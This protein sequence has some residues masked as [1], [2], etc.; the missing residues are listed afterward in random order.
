MLA[1]GGGCSAVAY[2]IA[3]SLSHLADESGGGDAVK[4]AL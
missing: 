1:L 4:P 2:V 3:S